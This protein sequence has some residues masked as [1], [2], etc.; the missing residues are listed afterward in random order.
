MMITKNSN[1]DDDEIFEKE[2]QCLK[3]FKVGRRWL[4]HPQVEDDVEEGVDININNS[5]VAPGGVRMRGD[6][7]VTNLIQDQQQ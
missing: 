7:R 2:N 4:H 5:E 3:T 1:D 6:T